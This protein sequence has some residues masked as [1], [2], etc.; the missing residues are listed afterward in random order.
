MGVGKSFLLTFHISHSALPHFAI[1]QIVQI[2]FGMQAAF[3]GTQVVTGAI[4]FQSKTGVWNVLCAEKE[5][6]KA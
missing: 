5:K 4:R 6:K 1:E 3:M 2:L